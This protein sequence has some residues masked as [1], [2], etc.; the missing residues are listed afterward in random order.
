MTIDSPSTRPVQPQA[1]GGVLLWMA[2]ARTLGPSRSR[3]VVAVLIALLCTSVGAAV[4]AARAQA[5]RTQ[6][7]I[8]QDD[9]QLLR[10]PAATLLRFRQL[11]AEQA[12]VALRWQFIAP[13]PNSFKAPR[14]F[15]GANPADYSNASWAPYDAIVRDANADGIAG[16]LQRRRRRAAVGDRPGHAEDHQ[17]VSVPQLG[18]E[19]R[20]LRPVHTGDRDSLQRQLQPADQALGAAQQG[21]SAA[22]LVLVDLE[23]AG[24]RSEPRAAGAPGSPGRRGQPAAVPAARRPGVVGAAGDGPRLRHRADRRAR[25]ARD[26]GARSGTSTGCR[27]SRSSSRSTAWA[28]TYRPLTGVAAALRGCPTTA[29]GSRRF[30]ADNPPLFH[31]SGFSDHPYMRWFPPNDEEDVP[32]VQ[33]FS[34]LVKGFTTLATIGNLETA[35]GRSLW[36][37]AHTARSRSGT[38]SSVT[39]RARPSAISAEQPYAYVAPA[40]AALLRQLGRVPVVEEP[41]ASPRSSSTCCMTPSPRPRPTTTVASRAGCC[42]YNGAQKPGYAAW[43]LPLFLPN[44]GRYQPDPA[45]RGVGR[46]APGRLRR[47]RPAD[48]PRDRSAAV[49]ARRQGAVHR[50]RDG[51]G[52]RPGGL[53]RQRSVLFPRAARVGCAGPTR[54]TR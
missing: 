25:P 30:V 38:R 14:T 18:A 54:Q 23:R 3:R 47:S 11:G 8:L 5:S 31:A 10:N 27:R 26:A 37:T 35:L 32:A 43:R 46:R 7:S 40:T 45:A 9:P 15:N 52:R 29:A 16:Q 13:S 24:L 44:D 39:S 22:R 53:F 12:R 41:A 17:G 1:T 21:R 2:P 34:S 19:R 6:V 28:P 4:L 42:H 49:R 33:G 36:A 50:A 51:P 20:R 48:A